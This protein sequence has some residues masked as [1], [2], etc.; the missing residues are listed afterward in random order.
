MSKIPFK[1]FKCS[2]YKTVHT[3]NSFMLLFM[4]KERNRSC[5]NLFMFLV[6]GEKLFMPRICYSY[7]YD[8]G[9]GKP[10]MLFLNVLCRIMFMPRIRSLIYL[11]AWRNSF[12]LKN[13][14]IFFYVL[15][16]KFSCQEFVHA[17]LCSC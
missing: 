9:G 14:F 6:Q 16:R 13:P 7:I 1:H 2:S 3:K 11:K 8:Q 12:M 5:K 4:F 17:L 15:G 10:F